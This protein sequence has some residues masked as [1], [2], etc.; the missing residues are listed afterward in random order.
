MIIIDSD[1]YADAGIQAF[2]FPGGEPHI[3]LP[4]LMKACT[5]VLTHLKL[6]TWA[7]VGLAACLHDALF[8]QGH[9][10]ST[11]IPYF[12]G[13]R[14][15]RSDG[16]TPRTLDLMMGL[17]LGSISQTATFDLHSKVGARSFDRN[18]L[19]ADLDPPR[20]TN[21]TAIIAPDEGAIDRAADF[22]NRLY[23]N[24][25]L[26]VASKVR[27]F[28]TGRITEYTL[29]ELK[30]GGHYIVVD[31]ICD[32]GATFNLLANAFD[33]SEAFLND[34]TLELFVSHGIFSKSVDALSSVYSRIT[35]TDSVCR[36]YSHGR[37][38]VLPLAPLLG[39]IHV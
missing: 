11:F 21:V 29:P 26:I 20:R 24:A 14:Q 17:L 1:H 8:F 16:H 3:I 13:A 33:Q 39:K 9:T 2:F 23:P 6:R 38:T 31:D 4:E 37:L 15:D 28:A 25:D 18:F 12:P 36:M 5:D 10:V 34:A 32:G 35:T 19:P 30:K 22:R 27:D 7:D